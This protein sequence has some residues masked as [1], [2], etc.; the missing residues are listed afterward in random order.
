MKLL[1]TLKKSGLGSFEAA[2]QKLPGTNASC[3]A[4]SGT[5]HYLV[6][7]PPVRLQEVDNDMQNHL[8]ITRCDCYHSGKRVSRVFTEKTIWS[9]TWVLVIRSVW[10]DKRSLRHAVPLHSL[11]MCCRLLIKIPSIRFCR[12]L[13]AVWG[14][15]AHVC[16][17]PQ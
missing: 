17:G 16:V 12:A 15:C 4:S 6:T 7:S 8:S 1:S 3:K 2:I 13:R 9:E 10:D 5:G 11:W 14:E